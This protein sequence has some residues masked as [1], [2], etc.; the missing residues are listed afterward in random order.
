VLEHLQALALDHRSLEFQ[1]IVEMEEIGVQMEA[2][3]PQPVLQDQHHL[4]QVLEDLV[5]LLVMQFQIPQ[6]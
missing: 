5:E 3:E 2:A 4:V 1:V 6:V